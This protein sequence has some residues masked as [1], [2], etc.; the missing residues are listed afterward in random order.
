[1]ISHR[2]TARI[3][4]RVRMISAIVLISLEFTDLF[5][6]LTAY[7]E[8][9]QNTR[10][11]R[12]LAVSPYSIQFLAYAVAIFIVM[13]DPRAF[14]RLLK[15]PIAAWLV[16][17]LGL[18]TWGMLV[19]TF[20][21]PAGFSD[22]D[23]LRA[24]GLQVHFLGTLLSFLVIFDDAE[25]IWLAKQCVAVAVLGGVALNLYEVV[26][27]GT[28]SSVTGRAAGLYVNSNESG[29][30]LVFGLLVSLPAIGRKWREL[31]I[32]LTFMGVA[33]TFSREAVLS[34]LVLL[35]G[36]SWAQML[37]AR[38]LLL[39]VGLCVILFAVFGVAQMM[40]QNKVLASDTLSRLSFDSGDASVSDRLRVAER[41]IEVF[42]AHPLLGQG[43]GTASYWTDEQTHNLYLSFMADYGILGLLVIPAMA[44]SLR[45]K[46]WDSYTF[47]VVLLLWCLFDHNLFSDS[48]A[49][50]SLAIQ[51]NERQNNPESSWESQRLSESWQV[52]G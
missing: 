33:A 14:R 32:L 43:F 8:P 47:A 34:L 3:A 1:M 51:A 21:T 49:L 36:A 11:L 9:N 38:R 48:F 5:F 4:Y 15:K 44:W 7:S 23:F 24:F 46:A 29:I 18:Y 20:N 2:I 28:F 37:S 27:P 19:R 10:Q 52:T 25:I 31:F 22:Y 50:I 39:G 17:T 16:A 6:F 40:R 13:L 26:N 30:A 42:E 41:A 35:I 12:R 45:R